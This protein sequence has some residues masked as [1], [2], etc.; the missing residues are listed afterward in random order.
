M[1]GEHWLIPS[2]GTTL[3]TQTGE[4]GTHSQRRKQPLT[5]LLSH[6]HPQ[7]QTSGGLLR[8]HTHLKG[9]SVRDIRSP[10]A[11]THPRERSSVRDIRSPPVDT[12]LPEGSFALSP[13]ELTVLLE[14]PFTH[15]HILRG[16]GL[17]ENSCFL[18]FNIHGMF[19]PM[20]ERERERDRAREEKYPHRI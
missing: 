13:P 9:S 14:A 19:E 1:P 17:K 16:Q 18:S 6:R 8:T 12:H 4:A 7:W 15:L 20:R 11:D 5:Q 2:R 3:S 10:P